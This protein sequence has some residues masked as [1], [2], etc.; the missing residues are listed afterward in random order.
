MSKPLE[1]TGERFTPEC[2]R[3]I[4]YEHMHRYVF[5]APLVENARVLD[6]ACGEGYGTRLLSARARHV[7]G[8]DI[9]AGS[10]EHAQARYGSD[11]LEFT[12]ADCCD[13]P[14]E[15]DSFDRVV[16]FETIEH[17]SDQTGLIRELRRVLH[18]DGF[19][20]MSSPDKAV[21][22]DEQ[23]ANNVFHVKELYRDEFMAL[24]GSQFPATLALEQALMFHSAIWTRTTGGTAVVDQ[25]HHHEAGDEVN[26]LPHPAARGMY[27]LA[28]C[29][30]NEACLPALDESLWLFD[31]AES[32]VYRHYHH[33]IRKN[34]SAGDILAELENEVARL[35]GLLGESPASWW[36]SLFGGR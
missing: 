2:V 23:G 36:R 32:S 29:G 21:Y 33:E 20:L 24:L 4:W 15:D 25:M 5:A 9:D 17:L 6:A 10:I 28:L 34:M 22:S 14:F 7:V 11:G 8:V 12:R 1:F 3:E 16:S 18:P 26:R 27:I 30:A 31:D 13:L 19:L 35:K